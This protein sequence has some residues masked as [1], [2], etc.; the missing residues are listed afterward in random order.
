[1]RVNGDY[2]NLLVISNRCRWRGIEVE[3]H[4]V[5]PGDPV[6]PDFFDLLLFG[7]G[8]DLRQQTFVADDLLKRKSDDIRKAVSDGL[9]VLATGGG[10]QLC[11]RFLQISDEARIPGLG[12]LD[13]WTV[14][15]ENQVTGDIIIDTEFLEP[16]TLVGF[17]SHSA[18]TYLG[19]AD[20]PM[21]RRVI[22][23]GNNGEDAYEGCRSQTVFGT[24]LHGPVLPRNPH[25][26]D[27]LIRLALERRNGIIPLA[28][29]DDSL[30]WEAHDRV[31]NQAGRSIG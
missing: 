3:V 1:M 20:E 26:S 6:P 16:G 13:T 10:F 27:H 14:D 9:V 22:G 28:P 31:L 15:G 4:A 24:Y 19:D 30:E 25:F 7:G 18:R 5:L 29:L 11:G 8:Q 17:E 21:G 23:Q 2:G 12:L